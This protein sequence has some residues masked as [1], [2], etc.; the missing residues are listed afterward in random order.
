MR[1]RT[2]MLIAAIVTAAGLAIAA[3][4]AFAGPIENTIDGKCCATP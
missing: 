4:S 3:P 2:L 1:R